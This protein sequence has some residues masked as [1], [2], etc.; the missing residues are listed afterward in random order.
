[1][2]ASS[3]TTTVEPARIFLA[4]ELDVL[5]GV[6]EE[7]VGHR[8]VAHQP[9]HRVDHQRRVGAK[10]GLLIGMLQHR[11]GT[12]GEHVRGG[13]PAEASA[14]LFAQQL[15]EV[16]LIIAPNAA[17]LSSRFT[18]RSMNFEEFG[19]KVSRSAYGTPSSTQITQGRHGKRELLH[20]VHRRVQRCQRVQLL[21]GD[22]DDAVFEQT[23]HL[24]TFHS[25]DDTNLRHPELKTPARY[26][27]FA[28]PCDWRW[29]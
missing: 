10:L 20:Q 24:I 26:C 25:Q 2:A 6:A 12:Q 16:W 27:K 5:G 3:E 23:S 18:S 9:F 15:A 11:E 7:D 19:W 22:C 13:L 1:M 17:I 29:S 21:H 8:Q 4:A 28:D 14:R